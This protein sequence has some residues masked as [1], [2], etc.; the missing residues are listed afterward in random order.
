MDKYTHYVVSECKDGKYIAYSV[1]I[2]NNENLVGFIRDNPA[3]VTFNV[4]DSKKDAENIAEF[5]NESY[6]KNEKYLS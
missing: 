1:R 5:W 3:I 2:R 4:C 6:K